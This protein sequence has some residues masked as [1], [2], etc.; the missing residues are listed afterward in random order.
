MKLNLLTQGCLSSHSIDTGVR[1]EEDPCS[2]ELKE[3]DRIDQQEATQP[4]QEAK[5]KFLWLGEMAFTSDWPM[6]VV[7]ALMV[8]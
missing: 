4:G 3:G 6:G 1:N 8:R 5:H 7:M 2:K